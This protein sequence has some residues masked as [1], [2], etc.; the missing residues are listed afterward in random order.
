MNDSDIKSAIVKFDIAKVAMM[1]A[2]VL[3]L[4]LAMDDGLDMGEEF[5]K[6][7]SK[8]LLDRILAKKK[9]YLLSSEAD[10]IRN[11]M[12]QIVVEVIYENQDCV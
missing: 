9:I 4:F 6:S 2:K 11:E 1:K 12:P 5:N 8:A 7:S 3:E 10:F